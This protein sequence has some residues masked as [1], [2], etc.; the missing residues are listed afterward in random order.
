MNALHR[1]P[2]SY[3]SAMFSYEFLDG[4]ID[5]DSIEQ[6]HR[7]EFDEWIFALAGSGFFTNEEVRSMVQEWRLNPKTLLNTLLAD[8]DEVTAKRCEVTWAAL[9]RVAPFAPSVPVAVFG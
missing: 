3:I 8:A 7:G 6:I 9:D 5:Y 1:D 4:G 2:S